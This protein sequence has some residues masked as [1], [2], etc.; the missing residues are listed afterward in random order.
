MNREFATNCHTGNL[1]KV[2]I[3]LDNITEE[4]IIFGYSLACVAGKVEIVE[5]LFDSGKLPSHTE[6][7]ED[8]KDFGFRSSC[9]NKT[10]KAVQEYFLKKLDY[11]PN[12]DIKAWMKII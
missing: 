3:E 6:N 2:K 4:D 5:F 11:A 9:G 12:D 8:I 7:G 1:D 10:G